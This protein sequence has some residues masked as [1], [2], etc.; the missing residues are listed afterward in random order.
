MITRERHTTTDTR[1]DDRALTALARRAP[2]TDDLIELAAWL[3]SNGSHHLSAIERI[4]LAERLITRRR[5]LIGAGAVGL[6]MI[7]G[8]GLQEE[9]AAPTAMP[10]DDQRLR[11]RPVDGRAWLCSAHE[12]GQH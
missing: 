8:C 11:D 2:A 10:S 5:F 12:D 1:T 3:Q 9:A 6:G 4:E 7:A